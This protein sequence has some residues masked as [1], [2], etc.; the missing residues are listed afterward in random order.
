MTK[1]EDLRV[2]AQTIKNE[3]KVGGNT[4]ERVGKAFEGVADAI[5]GIEQIKE[6]EKSVDAVKEKLIESKKAIEDMVNELPITQ[7]TGDSATKVM[8]QKAI[9]EALKNISLTTDDG[10]TLQDVYEKDKYLSK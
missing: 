7:E 3:T 10:N 9:T 4:A 1:V 5:E 6:M 8:S 2:L